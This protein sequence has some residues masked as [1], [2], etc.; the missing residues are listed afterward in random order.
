MECEHKNINKNSPQVK[1][2]AGGLFHYEAHVCKDC[3]AVLW[4]KDIEQKY[5][6]WTADNRGLFT[7]QFSISG[8][9]K[10]GINEI[11]SSYPNATKSHFVRAV[12]S[13]FLGFVFSSE[14]ISEAI[15]HV[16]KEDTFKRLSACKKRIKMKTR[17]NPTL[18][19]GV[20]TWGNILGMTPAKFIEDALTRIV[21][22]FV[23][24]DK[25][26]LWSKEIDKKIDII[27][28]AA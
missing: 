4:N 3:G 27:L 18:Y 25:I 11:I 2:I 10:L 15:N 20:E 21:S 8:D 12:L 6:V 13:V 19:E 14:I 7:I 24:R 1:K 22:I 17:M 16:S 9:V 23:D 5:N 28:M 26:D